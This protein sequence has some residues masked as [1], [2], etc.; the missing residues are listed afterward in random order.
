MAVAPVVEAPKAAE[1]APAPAPVV[2]ETTL[3]EVTSGHAELLKIQSELERLKDTFSTKKAENEKEKQLLAT[4]EQSIQQL[5][6]ETRRLNNDLAEAKKLIERL[7]ADKERKDDGSN[8]KISELSAKIAALE[9][10]NLRLKQSDEAHAQQLQSNSDD[11]KNQVQAA[12]A[13]AQQQK[14]AADELQAK[15][16]STSAELLQKQSQSA[17]LEAEKQALVAKL[18]QIEANESSK[19]KE[20]QQ[21][22]NH[23]IEVLKQEHTKALQKIKLE[24]TDNKNELQE[25]IDT[26]QAESAESLKKVEDLQQQLLAAQGEKQG[27]ASA[28][29]QLSKSA[30]A[31]DNRLADL[32][33]AASKYQSERDQFELQVTHLHTELDSVR[34]KN[35]SSAEAKDAE[36]QSLKA[37]VASLETERDE[38]DQLISDLRKSVDELDAAKASVADLSAKVL[39][40][41]TESSA[42]AEQAQKIEALQQKIQE[43]EAQNVSIAKDAEAKSAEALAGKD[44]KILELEEALA[45][46][47]SS[48][49]DELDGLRRSIELKEQENAQ[50]QERSDSIL[51]KTEE[52]SAGIANLQETITLLNEDLHSRNSK[53]RELEEALADLNS[54]T[55]STPSNQVPASPSADGHADAEKIAEFEQLIEQLHSDKA[56]ADALNAE[57][58]AQIHAFE[59]IID[60]QSSSFDQKFNS[61]SQENTDLIEE[62]NRLNSVLQEFEVTAATANEQVEALK[63]EVADLH[64]KL[65][66]ASGSGAG[67]D[68]DGASAALVQDL[69]RQIHEKEERINHLEFEVEQWSNASEQLQK[70]GEEAVLEISQEADRLRGE[71]EHWHKEYEEQYRLRKEAEAELLSSES[72]LNDLEVMLQRLIG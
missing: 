72:K 27:L 39:A 22:A 49:S 57:L 9:A 31:D 28:L 51:K 41:Q 62:V 25:Q 34:A 7:A 29:E 47:S 58:D 55:A 40:L 44:Q 16:E 46:R 11:L 35:A 15:L 48:S 65:N 70:L 36:I 10:E 5:N 64:A 12:Q 42:S 37:Q 52:L 71:V 14:Q 8:E 4:R 67:G 50:I 20:H 56:A 66:Q 38:K 13:L 1:P 68:F 6:D 53:I 26:A 19:Q 59:Q 54:K 33:L 18:Q 61:I 69:Q 24:W 32:Q 63:A 45:S 43:L 23:E 21:H 17:A 3:R 2:S 60:E 30:S